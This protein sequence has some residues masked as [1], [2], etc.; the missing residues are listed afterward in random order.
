MDK[1]E[2]IKQKIK[3]AIN[4]QIQ[5]KKE[6]ESFMDPLLDCLV[7]LTHV[8]NNPFSANA[9]TAGLPLVQHRLTPQLFIRA[10]QRAGLS[11]RIVQR[12]LKKIS[13][14][15]LPAILMLKDN[16][17]CILNKIL[18]KGKF[19]IILPDSCDGTAEVSLDELKEEYTGFAIFLKP[20]YKFDER[21]DE[22]HIAT[23]KSWFW[24]TLWGYRRIYSQVVLSAFLVN[25]FAL[26]TPLF[27]MNVYDRVV[28]NFAVETLWVLAIGIGIVFG[29]DLLLRTLR[30]YLIDIAG[31]KADTV[32]ASTLFHQAMN[33]QMSAR[34]ASSGAFANNLR[35]FEVLRDFFTS[36][37]VT[38]LVDLPFIFLFI[39][40]IWGVGGTIALVPLLAVPIVLLGAY[41]FEIPVR[42]A[43]ENSTFCST[44]KHAILIESINGLETIKSM[45]AEGVMQSKWEQFVGVA[46]KAGLRSRFFSTMA[47]NF[48]AFIS[49]LITVIIVITGVYLIA[50]GKLTTGGLIACVIM[51][52]RA[53]APLAH[54]AAIITRFNQS[55]IALKN[56]NK[57]MGLPVE[58]SGKKRYLHRP[59]F[60]ESIEF[61]KVSFQ[62]PGQEGYALKNV[63]FKITAG[64][65]VAILGPMGSGKSTLEKLILNLYSPTEGSIFFDGVETTQIDPADLRRNIG[66]V[67]QDY[68]LL[69]GNVHSNISLS[70]PWAS[71]QAILQAAKIANVDGFVSKHPAGYAMSIG[72]AGSGLSGGQRQAIA[73]AR[74]VLANPAILLLDEPTSSIDMGSEQ[75]IMGNL[76][77]FS[78]NKTMLL[79]THKVPL[80]SLVDRLIILADGEIIVDGQKQEVLEKLKNNATRHKQDINQD[81]HG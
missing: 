60:K 32:L 16:R 71:D 11:T 27:I 30:G 70:A 72:E 59:G 12:P 10:A 43:V 18:G 6:R 2:N 74:A 46:A 3:D 21:A 81:N 48:T 75:I 7:I 68:S 4:K 76:A 39:I 67:S 78:K 25:M 54:L 79:I 33:V 62:Y 51:N 14:L 9:L 35:E 80:L 58:R 57:I 42:K 63:S 13:R 40:I 23:K 66:Y 55:K 1:Q 69:Y 17:A 64:E 29:F 52:G 38:T 49:Q 65:K 53:I 44:Q 36:A 8:Y 73:I 19:E 37:T 31:K 77:Q 61:Y 26:A 34:P 56:L 20:V 41:F 28:P 50:A 15:V 5:A 22:F 45:G 47:V 24:G